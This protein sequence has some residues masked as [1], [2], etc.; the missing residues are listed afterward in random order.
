MA[1]AAGFG[2]GNYRMRRSLKP[3]AAAIRPAGA[4]ISFVDQDVHDNQEQDAKKQ[5]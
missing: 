2:K 4:L 1:E 5:K 3:A